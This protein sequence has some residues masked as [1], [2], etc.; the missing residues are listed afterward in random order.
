[1]ERRSFYE[2]FINSLDREIINKEDIKKSLVNLSKSNSIYLSIFDSL[3]EG[4]I[5]ADLDSY[6]IFYNK[7]ASV[8]F[9]QI[10]KNSIFQ[11]L[12]ED[13]IK[14]FEI[15]KNEDKTTEI[16]S[17]IKVFKS[18]YYLKFVINKIE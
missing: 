13:V 7:K 12:P 14:N 2:K 1:M 4:I 3:D 9:E 18:S 15:T 6:P 8:L 16:I 11:V 10:K 17:P 5:L